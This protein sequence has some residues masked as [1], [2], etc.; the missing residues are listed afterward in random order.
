[1]PSGAENG[2]SLEKQKEWCQATAFFLSPQISPMVPPPSSAVPQAHICVG[3]I[4]GGAK[5]ESDSA[6]KWQKE[7]RWQD[8]G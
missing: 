2:K 1:M 3:G 5:T 7:K 8:S 6:N 4:N